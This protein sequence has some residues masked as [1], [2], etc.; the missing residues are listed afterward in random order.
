MWFS[1]SISRAVATF[2]AIW[3]NASWGVRTLT[4]CQSGPFHLDDREKQGSLISE[5]N[6]TFGG[7]F[8]RTPKYSVAVPTLSA[9]SRT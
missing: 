6:W 7:G 3:Q 8:F 1:P 9:N 4:A 5:N 2:V